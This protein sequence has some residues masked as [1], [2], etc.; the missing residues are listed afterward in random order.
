LLEVRRE[1]ERLIA[2]SAA[3]RRTPEQG[4]TLAEMATEMRR[5]AATDDYL[6]FLR[7]D[8]SF[9]QCAAESA[10]LTNG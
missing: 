3:R 9:N 5:A 6:L 2:T 4:A 7:V 10:Q 8:H 1:L